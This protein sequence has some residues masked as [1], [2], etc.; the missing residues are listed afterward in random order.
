MELERSSC[1]CAQSNYFICFQDIASILLSARLHPEWI[2]LSVV[3]RPCSGQMLMYMR[4]DGGYYKQDGYLW[5]RRR[6][7]KMAREVG[8][9]QKISNKPIHRII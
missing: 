8:R 9:T 7:G 2:T 5:K 3:R 4:K 6:D 1:F